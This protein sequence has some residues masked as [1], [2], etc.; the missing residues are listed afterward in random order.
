MHYSVENRVYN[1]STAALNIIII[2]A[3]MYQGL[4]LSTIQEELMQACSDRHMNRVE[5]LL[6]SGVDPNYENSVS[7]FA[8]C[9][10]I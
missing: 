3:T 4:F 8:D 6:K 1:R 5:E 2:I 10:P 7:V 9:L